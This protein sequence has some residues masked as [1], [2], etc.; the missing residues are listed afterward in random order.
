MN[1]TK[2]MPYPFFWDDAAIDLSFV[3]KDE[4]PAGKRGFMRAE[5]ERFVFEDGTEGRFWG[6]NFNS[7][8]NFPSHEHS[9]KVAKRLAKFGVNIVRFHQMD[10]E[11]STPN[12]FQFSK[13]ENKCHTLEFDP[14]SMD[15]LDYL[16]HCLKEEGIYMSLD[17]LT[18]RK[19]KSEDGVEHPELLGEGAKPYSNFS[20]K[21]ID[22]QKR[23]NEQLFTHFNPY[24]KLCYKDDPAIAMTGLANENDLFLYAQK[25]VVLEPYRSELEALYREWAERNQ[26]EVPGEPVNFGLEP[27]EKMIAF[28]CEVHTNYYKEMMAHL[29][30][31]GVRIP[32]AGT[33]WPIN[34]A[35]LQSQSP[36]DY[37]DNHGYWWM[38]DQ[39]SINNS[40]MTSLRRSMLPMTG[41]MKLPDKPMFVSE[42]DSP[43][44]NEWRAESSLLLAAAGA[45]QGWAGFAIHT[46]RYTTTP[47]AERLGRNIALNGITYRGIFDSFNDP[48][49]F[50]LFYHAALIL[51]RGDV[52]Q[53]EKTVK[54]KLPDL[55]C[56]EPDETIGFFKCRMP[57]T[58]LLAESH[59]YVIE[60]PGY[61]SLDE[62]LT[63]IVLSPED[64]LVDESKG[65]VLS[66]TGEMYR[67]WDKRYGWID[68]PR[69]KVTYGFIGE[70]GAIELDGLVIE[71]ETDFATIAISSLT[72]EPLQASGNMLLT[73]VGRADNMD[74][75]YNEDHTVELQ[76]GHP[77]VVIEV[78]QARIR[79]HTDQQVMRV[80]AVNPEGFFT[81]E[82]PSAWKDG[83][84]SFE[85]GGTH[86]SMYYL[87]QKQ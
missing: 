69:T 25:P 27:D 37:T 50:G 63:E 47:N 68:S 14:D 20:R 33:N 78:T 19:F 53:G 51:R 46:Y 76:P 80:W 40:S 67:S 77:P 31:I 38:G 29:R 70:A 36:T 81:G 57:A 11:W 41:F 35:L 32:I 64:T 18:Y 75:Q 4:K 42:W 17:L 13:G 60:P 49:K 83:V 9:E 30:S 79:L 84:L 3:F 10:A 15:R 71:A 1:T 44:P 28:L 45:L 7:G 48:A 34:A 5:G 2:M 55:N 16:I 74:A 56:T 61:T 22:L 39:S 82:V 54:I 8:A 87:I 26:V 85:I 23:F 6:T 43:W 72:D 73:A 66:E 24:T 12:I 62:H 21:L 52:R 86:S 58:D 65:E 59:K